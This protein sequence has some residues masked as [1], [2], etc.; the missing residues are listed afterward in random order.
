MAA[1]YTLLSE[2][3]HND[4][5]ETISQQEQSVDESYTDGSE[6]SEKVSWHAGPAV[7]SFVPSFEGIRGFAV[8]LTMYCHIDSYSLVLA[9]SAGRSG[10]S[11]FFVLSGFLITGVLVH[12]QDQYSTKGNSR[13]R[14]HRHLVRFYNDR[15]VRLYPALLGMV[16]VS[17]LVHLW[18]RNGTL[19]DGTMWNAGL[20]LTYL[21]GFRSL[22]HGQSLWGHTWSLCV[23]EH[24]Y[25]MWSIM[26]PYI[27]R[28]SQSRTVCV[29]LALMGAVS[30]G[31]SVTHYIWD[32]KSPVWLMDDRGP[33][34]NFWKMIVGSA[35][36]L[37]PLP[38]WLFR[39]RMAWLGLVLLVI[40]FFLSYH[41]AGF[42]IAF[43]H[44]P[45]RKQ[46]HYNFIV[47]PV[48]TF[49]AALLV[50]GSLQGNWLLELHPI[51]FVGKISY[52]FYLYQVPL[53]HVHEGMKGFN[54]IGITCMA[55]VASMVSTF[56]I[57][58]PLRNRY[59]KWRDS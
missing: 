29:I 56:Y 35:L 59:R 43:L 54:A 33:L 2:R 23:E 4:S 14:S 34:S 52:S 20:V 32:I 45:S 3:R 18:M 39:K 19:R 31:L 38:A 47:E 27:R 28:H 6:L 5:D 48:A 30:Y 7:P 57:E 11:I 16:V 58:E 37:L 41:N 36:R 51:R 42:D 8:L 10:V 44:S 46:L 40:H 12:L 1:S 15:S 53:L 21:G 26:L 24:F 49:C 22:W 25:I 9:D 13:C 17:L 55:F 50:A